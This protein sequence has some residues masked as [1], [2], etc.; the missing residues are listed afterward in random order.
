M[1]TRN[2]QLSCNVTSPRMWKKS[3]RTVFEYTIR[4]YECRSN[5]KLSDG[6]DGDL[7]MC[8]PGTSTTLVCAGVC[9]SA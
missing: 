8:R 6:L 3:I 2:C 7:A 5:S 1:K 4:V 9:G